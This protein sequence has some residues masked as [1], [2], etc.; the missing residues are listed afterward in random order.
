MS[1]VF[2]RIVAELPCLAG[3]LI[4]GA[5]AYS[6]KSAWIWSWF[7]LFAFANIITGSNKKDES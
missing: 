1:I 6:D 5:L 7:L 3:L 2:F 4:A